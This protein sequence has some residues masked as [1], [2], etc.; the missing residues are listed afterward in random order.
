M[1][2]PGVLDSLYEALRC[3]TLE[4][5]VKPQR[6]I[7]LDTESTVDDALQTLS[8][9]KLLAAPV[10][11]RGSSSPSEGA[12]FLDIEDILTNFMEGAPGAGA[13]VVAWSW[14][15]DL[16]NELPNLR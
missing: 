7:S 1:A 16:A 8:Q 14:G 11:R 4:S 9:H 12:V 15:C 10:R 2:S 6:I 13:P 5:L 3:A